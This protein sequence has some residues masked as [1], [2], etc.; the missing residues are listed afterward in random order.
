MN[1]TCRKCSQSF[2]ILNQ[3]LEYY[4]RLSPPVSPPTLCPQCR[5]QRRLAFRNERCMYVAQS[6]LSGKRLISVISPDKPHQ[7]YEYDEWW[8]DRFSPLEY[9][10]DFDFSR[11]FFEQFA[12]L[13]RE[14]PHMAL[15]GSQNQN[16]PYCHLL[17]NCKNC[18][19]V[20]ESSNNEDCYYGYWLQKCLSCCDS[21]F[22]HGCQYCYE[23]ENCYDCYN[24]RWSKDCTA[25]YDSC[26]MENCIGCRN[27]FGCINLH[28]Q[29]Y[30][31]FNKKHS[32]KEYEDFL[33]ESSLESRAAI[34]KWSEKFRSFALPE[35]RKYSHILNAENCSG[36]Y[37]VSSKDCR[38]CYHVHDAEHCTYGEHVWRN[39]KFNMDVSTVGRGA[40]LVY[41][42]INTGISAYN[43]AF[44]IQAW[45]GSDLRYCYSCFDSKNSFGCVGLKK[46]SYCIFNKEYPREQ[47]DPLVSRII[48]H[49]KD[50]GE[51]GEFFPPSISPFGYNE[52]VAAEFFPLERESALAEGFQ[53]SDYEAPLPDLKE[54]QPLQ[55]EEIP[56]RL[57]GT[58]DEITEQVLKCSESGKYYRITS[59]ELE[60]YRAHKI[61]LPD[62]HPDV[63]HWKRLNQRNPQQLWDRSCDKCNSPILSTYAPDRPETVFCEKCF[64][65][66][67]F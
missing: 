33:R 59:Q 67:V 57:E 10:R 34:A 61:P 38:E 66:E 42:S 64:Q 43:N 13:L 19:L 41:E 2:E 29:E 62:L 47:Y 3:D 16:C 11:P 25:C 46:N 18:Y 17:A 22:V 32:R 14:V 58:G 6:A 56:D 37:V 27:C 23:V 28:Q 48:D 20:I 36:D 63:R 39:S 4:R 7:I 54:K 21:A 30:C 65:R 53:W 40:E 26:F 1:R 49:M 8:S 5:K 55:G 9:G 12:Q 52:S 24:L 31:I 51:Y 44:C 45:T 50:T 15:I 35:P 60:F